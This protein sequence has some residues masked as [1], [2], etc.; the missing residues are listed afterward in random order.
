[1]ESNRFSIATMQSTY[2]LRKYVNFLSNTSFRI[3]CIALQESRKS[4]V[5][6]LLIYVRNLFIHCF[7]I[8]HLYNW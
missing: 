7:N 3:V 4:I 6:S 5:N 8:I 1:M 2:L